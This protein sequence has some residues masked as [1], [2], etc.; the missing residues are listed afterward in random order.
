MKHFSAAHMI[1]GGAGFIAVNLARCLRERGEVVLLVDDLSRGRRENLGRLGDDPGVRF[2]KA[3]CADPEALRA[4]VDACGS[5]SLTVWH[6]AANSDI[7]AGGADFGVDVRRT[8]LTTT[9]VLQ[10]LR[11]YG[12]STLHFASSSAVYG[13]FGERMIDED[14]GPLAPISNYGAMKLAS[15]A[16]IRAAVEAFLPRAD[17]F[18]FPNVVGTP[19]THGVI[20]DFI[21]KLRADPTRLDVLGDGT[22]KKPYLHVDELVEAMLFISDGARGRFNV[23]NIGPQDDGVTVVTISEIV[24]D[25]ISPRAKIYYGTEPRGWVGD[26]PRFRYSV[27]RLEALGWRPKL[28]SGEAIVRAVHEIAR[29]Q[30]YECRP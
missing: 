1:T 25:T 5:P 21:A 6:L 16:Q 27:A 3:D 10:F 11:T 19:A 20:L 17:I 24:R 7:P 22:Q 8:F 13:D 4:A 29:D 23:F 18:R 15:E 12:P 26:V 14:V 28:T 9:G 2:V 30:G